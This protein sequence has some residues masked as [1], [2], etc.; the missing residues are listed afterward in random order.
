MGHF[1]MKNIAFKFEADVW[2]YTG[3]SPWHLVTLPTKIA[4]E[5]QFYQGNQMHCGTVKVIATIGSSTWDTALFKD[6]KSSSYLMPIK[7]AIRKAE[8]I[9]KGDHVQVD[10]TLKTVG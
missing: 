7:A 9:E 8:H 2:L 6:N 3:K 10:V 5:I 1:Y 4:E